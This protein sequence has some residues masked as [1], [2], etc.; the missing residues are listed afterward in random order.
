[1]KHWGLTWTLCEAIWGNL[2]ELEASLEEPSEYI[3]ALERRK[4]FSRWLSETA[5]GRIEEEVSLSRHGNHV[6][7]VFSCLT[8]KRIG[9]ACRLAQQSGKTFKSLGFLRGGG[10]ETHKENLNFES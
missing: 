7:A 8:G 2:K 9:E 6:E 4:A 5:A 1:M 3:L 10:R